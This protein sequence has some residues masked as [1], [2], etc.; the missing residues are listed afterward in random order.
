MR[1]TGFM[2]KGEEERV[3][4]VR[5]VELFL[6]VRMRSERGGEKREATFVQ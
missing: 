6:L 2:L 1:F 4:V 3:S 5:F